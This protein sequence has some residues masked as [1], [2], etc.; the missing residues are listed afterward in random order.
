[1]KRDTKMGQGTHKHLWRRTERVK[2]KSSQDATEFVTK[3]DWK[4]GALCLPITLGYKFRRAPNIHLPSPE[5]A[6]WLW[7]FASLVLCHRAWLSQWCVH[8]ICPWFGAWSCVDS[9][10][11]VSPT[12]TENLWTTQCLFKETS[13][14]LISARIWFCDLLR[15]LADMHI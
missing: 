11:N 12:H 1:M 14:L 7:A 15:T 9:L 4:L 5:A 8:W 3:C 13:F 10:Q 6:A 2:K